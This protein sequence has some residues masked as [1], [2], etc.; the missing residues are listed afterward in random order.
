MSTA[1]ESDSPGE[2]GGVATSASRWVENLN[3]AQ[4]AYLLLA[5]V[6]ALLL[7]IAIWP[8]FS[9][10]RMSLHADAL[11]G[12]AAIGQ[13]V[14]F[15]N[16]V[17]II[18]GQ[19]DASLTQPF[20]DAGH[21]FKSSLTVTFIFA[22]VSVLFETLIGFGQALV[23]DQEFRGRRWVRVAIIIPWAIPIVIQGMIFFLLFQ[24][25]VGFLTGPLQNMG[26]LSQ[27]PLSTSSDS[28]WIIIV[29]DI[30]KTSAFVAL[31]I[32][33]GLQSIDR[34][35]YDVAKVAGATRWQ[36]FRMITFPLVLP[37]I[38]VAL[39]FRTIQAMRVYGIIQT[40]AGCNVVPSLSCLVVDSF[41]NR[42]YGTSSTIA[43]ITALIIAIAVSVY[44][45]QFAKEGV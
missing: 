32:L 21:L 22:I 20:F 39:L 30:W 28:L 41:Q 5:P 15:Q 12:S 7:V 4:F 31:L 10:F 38:L 44:I 29:A 43:F 35:L 27:T 11:Y 8:L 13:F 26:L 6:F 3:D 1:T 34:N 42:L 9:T 23:L 45:F 14:G 17:Q 33:A 36:Q 24:P 2:G 18:T 19:R 25:D 16:Y 37:T 40:V